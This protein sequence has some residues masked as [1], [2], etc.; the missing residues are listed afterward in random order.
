M[1]GSSIF[2]RIRLLDFGVLPKLN[3]IS[4]LCPKSFLEA[5]SE[6]RIVSLD[7]FGQIAEIFQGREVYC[8]LRI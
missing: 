4:L 1:C 2:L 5:L 6:K 8:R 7:C 3:K